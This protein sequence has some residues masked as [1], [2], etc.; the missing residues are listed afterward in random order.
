MLAF[1]PWRMVEAE[2][3]T[4]AQTTHGEFRG[5][6][7]RVGEGGVSAVNAGNGEGMVYANNVV[8]ALLSVCSQ[9][10]ISQVVAGQTL[11]SRDCGAFEVYPCEPRW[12]PNPSPC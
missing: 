7:Q 10:A 3:Y 2:L 8:R 5:R 4:H 12:V 1:T 6:A 9:V 11:V